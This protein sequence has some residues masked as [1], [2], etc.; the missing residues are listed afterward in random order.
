[1]F[2]KTLEY[3]VEMSLK[4]HNLLFPKE[5]RDVENVSLTISPVVVV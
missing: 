1:M 5:R 4:L 3:F 2:Q